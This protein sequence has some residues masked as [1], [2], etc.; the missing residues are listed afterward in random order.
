MALAT[1]ALLPSLATGAQRRAAAQA[2]PDADAVFQAELL[3]Y[4][5]TLR[6]QHALGKA[7]LAVQ[8]PQ[9]STE[10]LFGTLAAQLAE[11]RAALAQPA[12]LPSSIAHQVRGDFRTGNTVTVEGWVLSA[13][14]ARLCG[15]A[16]RLAGH[17]LA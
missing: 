3:R 15:L 4:A 8:Q 7:W 14:E 5:R 16:C 1:A 11:T 9:P 17:G 2:A 10:S 12:D 13:T 6:S